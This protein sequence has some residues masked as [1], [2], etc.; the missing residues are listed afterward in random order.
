MKW[1]VLTLFCINMYRIT[2]ERYSIFLSMIVKSTPVFPVFSVGRNEHKFVIFLRVKVFRC[3]I[4]TEY[5]VV[6]PEWTLKHDYLTKIG[7]LFFLDFHSVRH[8][9]PTFYLVVQI[10]CN[11]FLF[12]RFFDLNK[13][14]EQ[15]VIPR[16]YSKHGLNSCFVL[17]SI[18]YCLN[19]NFLVQKFLSI[20]CDTKMKWSFGANPREE[21]KFL[22]LD[23][24]PSP[25]TWIINV[26]YVVDF[27]Q[28]VFWHPLNYQIFR[29]TQ[30]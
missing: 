24:L 13:C 26:I 25:N 7:T 14:S 16:F 21:N 2:Q 27:N 5:S 20:P 9:R 18:I 12:V 29:P 3:N 30:K 11:N 8:F 23:Y 1:R 22:N 17:F 28:Y 4:L 10:I 19:S 15:R 6:R